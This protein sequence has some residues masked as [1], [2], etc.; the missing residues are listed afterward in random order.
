MSEL[1]V[2]S[3]VKREK[4]DF[5]EITDTLCQPV[6]DGWRVETISLPYPTL[7]I[8]LAAQYVYILLHINVD[9]STKDIRSDDLETKE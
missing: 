9:C 4:A 3:R 7:Y 6:G 1:S 2:L 8:I 5:I